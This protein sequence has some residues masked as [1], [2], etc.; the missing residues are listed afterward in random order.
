ME[1]AGTLQGWYPNGSNN[2]TVKYETL[3][4]VDRNQEPE[5]RNF[6]LIKMETIMYCLIGIVTV[7]FVLSIIAVG[8][9]IKAI[10]QEGKKNAADTG[11]ND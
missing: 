6:N 2:E 9:A 3:K 7:V 10:A 11:M 4:P 1:K 8:E 5:T